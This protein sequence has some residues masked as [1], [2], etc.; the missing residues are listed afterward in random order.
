MQNYLILYN[1]YYESNAI[2]KHLEILKAQ[3]QVVFGKLCSKLRT[4][5]KGTPSMIQDYV[6]P[7]QLF[8]TDYENFFV[9]KIMHLC[10][11]LENSLIAPNYYER[12]DIV[13]W[14]LRKPVRGE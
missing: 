3:G 9:A 6:C 4:D 5:I 2:D 11:K 14:Y 13:A 8:L 12:L 10:L 1:P 7:L